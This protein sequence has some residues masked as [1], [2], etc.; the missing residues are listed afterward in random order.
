MKL[1]MINTELSKKRGGYILLIA[2][3]MPSFPPKFIFD[4][5]PIKQQWYF[6]VFF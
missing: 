1:F 6:M 2:K 4:H 5:I 3:F